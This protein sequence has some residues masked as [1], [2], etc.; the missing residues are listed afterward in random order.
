MKRANSI[1]ATLLPAMLMLSC[2]TTEKKIAEQW[3][4]VELVFH[5]E[6]TYE[7]PYTDVEF[8]AVFVGNNND[9]LIRPGFWDGD[10]IWK[11]RFA[12]PV[13]KGSYQWM[14][15]C[16]NPEDEGLHR[17]EGTLECKPYAGSNPLLSHGL[18]HMSPGMRNVVHSDGTP[19]L[20]IGDTPWALPWRGTT[21]TVSVYAKDRMEKGFNSALLMTMMSDRDV[22]GPESRTEAGGFDVAF[23][24]LADGHINQLKPDYFQYFD[25]LVNI[26]IDH[27]IIP[28]YQPVFHGF[29]W[30]G[31]NLLGWNMEP[32]ENARYCRYLV[33]RY[34]ARPAMYLVG[35]DSDGKNPGVKEGGEEIEKWDAY[36]QPTGLHY[37]PFDEVKPDWMS[38]DQNYEPHRN[39]TFQDANWLDFQWC[40]TG[41]GGIHDPSKVEKMY[42]NQPVKAVANGEPTYEGIRDPANGSDWWQGHEAW[43]QFTS[44]STMGV[45][46]G[47]GGLWNWKLFPGE[48]GWPA[49]ADSRVSWRE[50][51]ELPGSVYPGYL[52]KA[53]EGLDITDIEKHP[54]LAGG[55]LCLAKPGKLY[56]VYLPERAQITINGLKEGK[57]FRWF[58]PLSGDFVL[59]GTI[60]D[61]TLSLNSPVE[62]PSVLIIY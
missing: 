13:S 61:A 50:A 23:E 43:L 58:N 52:N 8:H 28:V 18:L 7:N 37:S 59:E 25:T 29:G 48:E 32:S 31:K 36:N 4:E 45:V 12:S 9:T 22:K 35:A 17:L 2:S 40:Q 44:G 54:E 6:V 21:E 15:F 30:K 33:A 51:I 39:R 5:S 10:N 56:V 47:A 11:I 38:T 24:D 1:L 26:L 3:K 16:S 46:Y 57:D 41:H 34:G 42:L 49:W 19:F 62:G 20:V 27:G 53:L 60:E 14:T 55:Q